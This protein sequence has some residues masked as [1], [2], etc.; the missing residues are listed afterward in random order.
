[1]SRGRRE[2]SPKFLLGKSC[3]TLFFL[4]SLERVDCC[5]SLSRH[6]RLS[7]FNLGNF[8]HNANSDLPEKNGSRWRKILF[9]ISHHNTKV[10]LK[11]WYELRAYMLRQ[12][13]F[14]TTCNECNWVKH[15]ILAEKRKYLVYGIFNSSLYFENRRWLN[16]KFWSHDSNTPRT[17]KFEYPST[18]LQ[19]WTKV[20]L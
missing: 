10:P 20:W 2:L 9:M 19:F 1:M 4:V 7:H 16:P 3:G 13:V 17:I 8:L 11:Q 12:E 14:L 6:K 5:V 15:Y 18:I